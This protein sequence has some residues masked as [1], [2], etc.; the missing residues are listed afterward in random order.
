MPLSSMTLVMP[1]GPPDKRFL[2]HLKFLAFITPAESLLP[3]K[4]IGTGSRDWDLNIFGG[5]YLAHTEGI[6]KGAEAKCSGNR[7]GCADSAWK[8]S[9]EK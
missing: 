2:S 6:I 1:W 7:G 8:V 5:H 3:S 9:G 4:I